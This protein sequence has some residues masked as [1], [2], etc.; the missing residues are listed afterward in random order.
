MER[1][2]F[3][4]YASYLEAANTLKAKDRDALY[5]AILEY[6]IL[7]IEPQLKGAP[8]TCWILIKPQLDANNRKYENGKRGGRPSKSFNF[9]YSN[10]KTSGYC[11]RETGGYCEVETKPEPNADDDANGNE[12]VQQRPTAPPAAV[13]PHE[14]ALGGSAALSSADIE[15]RDAATEAARQRFL[16][17]IQRPAWAAANAAPPDAEKGEDQF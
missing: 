14:G 6:G 10:S 11:E 13:A 17:S 8:L 1:K 5:R 3:V 15:E 12:D 9:G 4:F 7:G 16:N 2:S